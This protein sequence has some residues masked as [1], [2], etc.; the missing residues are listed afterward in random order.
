MI[1]G[2]PLK[3]KLSTGI[4]PVRMSQMPNKI[5][6]RLLV[7]LILVIFYPLKKVP[8]VL[9]TPFVPFFNSLSCRNGLS[10][11]ANRASYNLTEGHIIL[12]NENLTMGRQG[13][14]RFYTL[15]SFTEEVRVWMFIVG[16][17]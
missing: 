3:C 2:K 17:P 16:G 6:P 7:T 12:P 14:G 5:S 9:G 4:S 11:R 13:Q 15:A 8:N 10:K 1:T